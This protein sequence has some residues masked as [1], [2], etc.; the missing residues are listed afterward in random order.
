MS[1]SSSLPIDDLYAF[2]KERLAAADAADIEYRRVVLE[3]LHSLTAEPTKV[4]YEQVQCPGTTRPAIWC[5]PLNAS[6][7]HVLLY[8]HGGAGF[9]GSPSS[10]RKLAGHL[11][12]AV[13]CYAIVLDYALVPEKPFPAGLNDAVAAYEWL[14]Q[15]GFSP[16]NI[17]TVGDSAGG[18]LAVSAILEAKARGL[19]TPSAAAA[20]SPWFDM[21]QSGSSIHENAGKDLLATP[22][23]FQAISS[24]YLG[25][26]SPK[27]PLA[28]PLYADFTGF[29]PL[30]LNAGGVELL[31]DNAERLAERARSAGCSVELDIEPGMQHV[32][33]FMA[34]GER[35]ADATMAKAAKWLKAQLKL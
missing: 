33:V 17:A 34:G 15:T 31:A 23:T 4:T 27:N 6:P 19:P 8:T 10:H 1:T 11:S 2:I 35:T 30:F 29:P 3:T 24:L 13:G 26:T 21:E 18:N 12:K 7:A 14:L 28:N 22:E 32:Y 16:Q 20:F 5:K 25:G 9:A